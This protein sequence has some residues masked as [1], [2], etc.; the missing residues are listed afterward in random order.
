MSFRIDDEKLLGK[1]ESIWTKIEDLTNFELNALAVSDDS[2]IK[3]KTRIYGDNVY[4]N[5]CDLN[6]PEKNI[7]CESF[8]A[9]SIDSLLVYDEKYCLQ[10]YLDN[11]A[12]KIVNKQ[13][14]DNL[15]KIF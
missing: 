5:F 3:T 1:Y 12:Y 8:T 6:V 13:M 11:C 2:Y 4:A 9:I 15:Q 10:V 14:T 7:E